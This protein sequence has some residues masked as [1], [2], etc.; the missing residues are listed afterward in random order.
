MHRNR[1]AAAGLLAFAMLCGIGRVAIGAR[2]EFVNAKTIYRPGDKVELRFRYPGH[3]V[4][5]KRAER[6]APSDTPWHDLGMLPIKTRGPNKGVATVV[7]PP[8][9][10][11]GY[12]KLCVAAPGAPYGRRPNL[13][14]FLYLA[15][16]RTSE[17]SGSVSFVLPSQRA[18]FLQKEPVELAVIVKAPG[19]AGARG[20]LG[21]VLE[22][23]GGW[24]RRIYRE[25]VT[26]AAGQKTTLRIEL[27]GDLTMALRPG[28]YRLS[29][30]L[31]DCRTQ[32]VE[33]EIVSCIDRTHAPIIRWTRHD[34]GYAGLFGTRA[35][36]Q[37]VDVDWSYRAEVQRT[38]GQSTHGLGF[39]LFK[40]DMYLPPLPYSGDVGA[41]KLKLPESVSLPAPDG[42]YRPWMWRWMM[43][44]LLRGRVRFVPETRWAF[45]GD[46]P[47]IECAIPE[48]MAVQDRKMQLITQCL[49]GYPHFVG[50][51]YSNWHHMSYT[52]ALR[53]RIEREATEVGKRA[54]LAQLADGWVFRLDP[55]GVGRR[56]KWFA[57]GLEGTGWKP[58]RVNAPWEKQ[59]YPDYDGAGWYRTTFE[60]PAQA[61][62]QRLYL[63]FKGVDEDPTVWVNGTLVG[64]RVGMQYWN[65]PWLV[66]IGK[67]VRAGEDNTLAVRVY[68]RRYAGGIFRGVSLLG[69]ADPLETPR[70][71]VVHMK[72]TT[73]VPLAQL[74]LTRKLLLKRFAKRTRM[75]I[76]SQD[77]GG[78]PGWGIPVPAQGPLNPKEHPEEW[79]AWVRFLKELP[80]EVHEGW[81]RATEEICPHLVHT[82]AYAHPHNRPV[83]WN[84]LYGSCSNGASPVFA[85]RGLDVITSCAIGMDVG[86]EPMGPFLFVDLYATCRDDG[87]PIWKVSAGFDNDGG[88]TEK[89]NYLRTGLANLS[90]GAIPCVTDTLSWGRL[91]LQMNTVDEWT[92]SGWGRRERVRFLTTLCERYGDVFLRLKPER[93]VAL[94]MSLTQGCLGKNPGLDAYGMALASLASGYPASMIFEEDILRGKLSPYKVLLVP[95]QTIELP[96][97][98]KRKISAWVQQGGRVITDKHTKVKFPG[99]AQTSCDFGRWE[100][101]VYPNPDSEAA[102]SKKR[103][104]R[105]DYS[106]SLMHGQGRAI[107]ASRGPILKGEIEKVLLGF[108]RKEKANLDTV[109]S[110]M[111]GGQGR[112]LFAINQ[113]PMFGIY[114][115]DRENKGLRYLFPVQQSWTQTHVDRVQVAEGDYAVYDCL[116]GRAVSLSGRWLALDFRAAEGRLFAVLPRPI[117]HV[118]LAVSPRA[119]SGEAVRVRALVC[120]SKNR[121]IDAP[122]PLEVIVTSPDG[123]ERYR[124]YRASD[125]RPYEEVFPVA[126]NHPPGTWRV[127]ARELLSG[128]YAEAQ[129]DVISKRVKMRVDR[130][131]DTVV[132]DRGAIANFMATRRGKP[133]VVPVDTDDSFGAR[134]ADAV[135]KLLQQKGIKARV[136]PVERIVTGENWMVFANKPENARHRLP[137]LPYID[138]DVVVVGLIGKHELIDAVIDADILTRRISPD[139]PGRGHG[140][141]A[142]AWSC[143]GG[144]RDAVL[145][146]SWDEEG[147]K[148]AVQALRRIAASRK[149]PELSPVD[150]VRNEMLPGD[151]ARYLREEKGEALLRPSLLRAGRATKWAERKGAAPGE[152]FA[153]WM[154]RCVWCLDIHG[155]EIAAGTDADDANVF[156][157]R[158]G[159]IA[160]KWWAGARWVHQIG[161]ADGAQ[162]VVVATTEDAHTRCFD[163]KGKVIWKSFARVLWDTGMNRYAAREW[164]YFALSA[165]RRRVFVNE[166]PSS[167]VCRRAG[168]GA[169]V[170]EYNCDPGTPNL[171]AFPIRLAASPTRDELAVVVQTN[172]LDKAK[173]TPAQWEKVG[174]R[175]VRL[176][177]TTGKVLAEW[178]WE[179]K[180]ADFKDVKFSDTPGANWIPGKVSPRYPSRL[181]Y[182]RRYPTQVSYISIDSDHEAILLGHCPPSILLFDLEG[183]PQKGF[184]SVAVGTRPVW[185]RPAQGG[186]KFAAW[187]AQSQRYKWAVTGFGRENYDLAVFTIGARKTTFVRGAESV[188]DVAFGKE[189]ERIYVGR[190][191]G[192]VAAYDGEGKELWRQA[193]GAGA[194]LAVNEAGDVLAGT[195]AGELVCMKP[196]GAVRWR[197]PLS[198][199]G[200]AR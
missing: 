146:T 25:K 2:P 11:T 184:G 23:A 199:F 100:E 112:Y 174:L 42:V 49:R 111:R 188:S 133:V 41:T 117:D 88:V 56:Q 59:G 172:L 71:G 143:F 35:N 28:T 74:G 134:M 36:H 95:R 161:L 196:D 30:K 191:D 1:A 85:T 125:L 87:K 45:G 89:G 197:V 19:G 139:Y 171:T 192:A 6:F 46:Q 107:A 20:S 14:N 94:L 119:D 76:S 176:N 75:A 66:E 158:D 182:W 24:K 153:R 77:T 114:R 183:H 142:H 70:G 81:R 123:L 187:G 157:V 177:G 21:V 53:G 97:D 55:D 115:A 83:L 96:A 138:E 165:D 58:I 198:Y 195:S 129:V 33:I 169:K 160:G 116:A 137:P 178:S 109:I 120:D 126:V 124:V 26:V 110:T 4:Y 68:D 52:N 168:D 141:V 135:C 164:D 79:K 60:V 8:D 140:L 91:G 65:N 29:A 38:L 12:Y 189:P 80:S 108:A 167:V 37:R 162:R 39:N 132:L 106:F 9:V 193:I 17:K 122:V 180:P 62:G 51:S 155:G 92:H 57:P 104:A 103:A 40:V 150:L 194:R 173:L 34:S 159:R 101:A 148:E 102:T 43:D 73:R 86:E 151:F 98:V 5:L 121:A 50:L 47:Y 149:R 113:K 156:L 190:W 128:R 200:P 64:R 175:V 63:Y 179:S 22:G 144:H 93:D 48:L 105:Y 118:R 27:S 136:E 7:L 32:P 163:R 99:M 3:H 154:G 90:R 16:E 186:L 152:P 185:L 31:A 84:P 13:A 166:A 54:P 44:E 72:G 69:S 181:T 145:V 127:R 67:A 15:V 131:P 130:L 18:V 10:G 147:L 82:D 78:W 170:W 61:K